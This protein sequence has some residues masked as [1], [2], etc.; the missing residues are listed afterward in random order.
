MGENGAGKSTLMK[1]LVGINP[2]DSGEIF[3]K[4]KRVTIP[5][6]LTALRLGIA[7]IYQELNPVAE[8]SVMENIWLGREPTYG[9]L[10]FSSTTRPCS[11]KRKSCWPTSTST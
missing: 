11:R 4:S 9:R 3:L 7:M 8:R 10:G 1:C 5:N 2:P 6:P